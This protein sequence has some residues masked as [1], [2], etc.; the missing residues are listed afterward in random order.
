M[1]TERTPRQSATSATILRWGNDRLAVDYRFPGGDRETHVLM[2]D[3]RL[4]LDRLR[5]AGQVDYIDDE[6]RRRYVATL[7]VAALDVGSSTGT[8]G[9]SAA[10]VA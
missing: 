9:T 8:A 1:I 10:C 5:R 3:D 6:V 2:P 7:K 4:I